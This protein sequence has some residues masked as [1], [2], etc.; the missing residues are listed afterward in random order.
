MSAVAHCSLQ[1]CTSV[2]FPEI[3]SYL[4]PCIF[5]I[6]YMLRHDTITSFENLSSGLQAVFSYILSCILICTPASI[7]PYPS[8]S[9]SISLK[10]ARVSTLAVIVERPFSNLAFPAPPLLFPPFRNSLSSSSTDLSVYFGE[11]MPSA[12]VKV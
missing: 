6:C 8:S 4:L 9:F 11:L 10:V 1:P 12:G 3:S 7:L 2:Y 5:V